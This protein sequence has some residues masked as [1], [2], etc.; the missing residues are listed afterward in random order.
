VEPAA[1][2]TPLWAAIERGRHSGL[3]PPERMLPPEAVARA[4]LFA[5]TAPAEVDVRNIIL[6]RT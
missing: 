2:E 4:V 5:V 3:P 6:D 1:T